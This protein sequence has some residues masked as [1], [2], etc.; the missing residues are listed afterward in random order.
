ML[1]V[2]A[3]LTGTDSSS[4]L[5]GLPRLIKSSNHMYDFFKENGKS[6]SSDRLI[7]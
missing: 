3:Q 2:V 7:T 1:A 6:E 4:S 5:L